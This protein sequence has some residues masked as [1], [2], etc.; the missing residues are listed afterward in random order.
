MVKY[1][2]DTEAK[3]LKHA[4]ERDLSDEDGR[5][6]AYALL[7]MLRGLRKYIEFCSN[8]GEDAERQFNEL[9]GR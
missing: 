3:F 9:M 2:D 4:D 5:N 6:R 8:D 7:S 1:F